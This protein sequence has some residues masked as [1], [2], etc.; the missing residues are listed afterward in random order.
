MDKE[1][2]EDYSKSN[3]ALHMLYFKRALEHLTEM[4]KMRKKLLDFANTNLIDA[5]SA[6]Q[7]SAIKLCKENKAYEE[8]DETLSII[9]PN[10]RRFI[11]P[12]E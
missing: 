1:T 3:P 4:H 5:A 2:T 7:D 8:A 11:L 6:L 9:M 12:E 10:Y